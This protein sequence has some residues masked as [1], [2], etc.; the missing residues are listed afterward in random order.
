MF[1]LKT[2]LYFALRL[3]EGK[4]YIELSPT[5]FDFDITLIPPV[6]FDNFTGSIDDIV[7][8][9]YVQY[10]PL[11]NEVAK[12]HA[13]K[14]PHVPFFAEPQTN[15]QDGYVILS[16]QNK[17]PYTPSAAAAP[18]V[19]SENDAA[20]GVFALVGKKARNLFLELFFERL[21]ANLA[22][23]QSVSATSVEEERT[24]AARDFF[25]PFLPG[26]SYSNCPS[27]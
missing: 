10:I 1:D 14:L 20:V 7:H 18:F 9:L 24:L 17:N 15:V 6:N 13:L 4:L 16:V 2:T 11:L 3:F 23:A 19:E 5:N 22:T 12:E 26:F 27:N 8:A 25:C 21:A